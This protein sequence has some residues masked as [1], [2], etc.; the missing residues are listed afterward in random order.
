M[1]KQLVYRSD[2]GSHISQETSP[3]TATGDLH[4]PQNLRELSDMI[5]ESIGKL[6]G[7]SLGKALLIRLPLLVEVHGMIQH[8]AAKMVNCPRPDEMTSLLPVEPFIGAESVADVRLQIV[9]PNCMY[10]LEVEEDAATFRKVA[11]MVPARDIKLA[12]LKHTSHYSAE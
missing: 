10:A 4:D 5:L 9:I 12:V 11:P 8:G 6:S 2:V 1:Q 7:E 3:S